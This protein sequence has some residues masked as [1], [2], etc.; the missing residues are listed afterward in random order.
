MC[1]ALGGV[2]VVLVAV[3]LMLSVDVAWFIGVVTLM[4]ISLVS[5]VMLHQLFP[6]EQCF[7]PGSYATNT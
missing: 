1:F 2:F 7:P 6:P 4:C 3:T 5:V